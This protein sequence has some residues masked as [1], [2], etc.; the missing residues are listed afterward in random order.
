MAEWPAELGDTHLERMRQRDADRV[1]DQQRQGDAYKDDGIL[2]A[3]PVET[4][5]HEDFPA[6]RAT[7]MDALLGR[8]AK[9]IARQRSWKSYRPSAMTS[10][11]CLRSTA[12]FPGLFRQRQST[13][14]RCASG[15]EPAPDI[16]ITNK[17]ENTHFLLD[18]S[19]F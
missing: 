1:Y 11:N 17:N 10:L 5:L 3:D 7:V 4:V 8:A 16:K 14:T 19:I 12:V 18:F 6:R 9:K 2:D 15:D 13:K